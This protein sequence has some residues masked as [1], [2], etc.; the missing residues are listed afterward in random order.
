MLKLRLGVHEK[1]WKDH[2]GM[3]RNGIEQNVFKQGKGMKKKWN[4]M[5]LSNFYWMF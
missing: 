5:K 4:G 3:K 1:E 2:K